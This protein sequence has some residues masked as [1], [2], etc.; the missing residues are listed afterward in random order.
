M[1]S[2]GGSYGLAGGT[3]Y[4]EGAKFYLK[5]VKYEIRDDLKSWE[6]LRT[7]LVELWG[8]DAELLLTD[9]T[10]QLSVRPEQWSHEQSRVFRLRISKFY[11]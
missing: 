1:E 9:Q 3:F 4:G 6:K 8:E 11:E 2:D 7:C 10:Q 5:A